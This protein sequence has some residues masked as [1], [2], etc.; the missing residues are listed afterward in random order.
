MLM[1]L[2]V[3]LCVWHLLNINTSCEAHFLLGLLNFGPN[4]DVLYTSKYG[5][6]GVL[7][8]LVWLLLR[9]LLYF[10]K[11]PIHM[12][13]VIQHPSLQSVCNADPNKKDGR[14]QHVLAAL[15]FYICDLLQQGLFLTVLSSQWSVENLRD[16]IQITIL[17]YL[18]LVNV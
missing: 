11:W 2:P 16:F 9:S 6:C 7:L 4:N 12:V 10:F 15:W 8:P 14:A 3:P 5:S 1:E 13:Q 17:V 18:F